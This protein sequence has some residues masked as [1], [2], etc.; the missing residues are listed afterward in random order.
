MDNRINDNLIENLKQAKERIGQYGSTD[1]KAA[2]D[3][4]AMLRGAR[5][6]YNL[7][8]GAN[9]DQ[10]IVFNLTRLANTCNHLS[11]L[12]PQKREKIEQIQGIIAK[13]QG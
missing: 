1:F 2:T 12:A 4:D 5:G 7:A 13:L 6:F 10:E 11:H 8:Y 3:A 9:A